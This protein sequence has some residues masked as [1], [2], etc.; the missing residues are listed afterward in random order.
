MMRIVYG[1]LLGVF[2]SNTALAHTGLIPHPET[3]NEFEHAVLHLLVSLVVAFI[4][5]GVLHKVFAGK[6][7]RSK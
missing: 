4:L 1:L 2:F 7:K 5:Y 6:T 3:V